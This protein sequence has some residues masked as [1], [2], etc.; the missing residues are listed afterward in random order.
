VSNDTWLSDEAPPEA[1][2]LMAPL[3]LLVALVVVM[4]LSFVAG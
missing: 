4:G 3:A 1:S 2:P